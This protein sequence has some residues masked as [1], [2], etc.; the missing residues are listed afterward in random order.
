[1]SQTEFQTL[2]P[3]PSRLMT[4]SSIYSFK[5]KT[6]ESSVI[7]VFISISTTIIKFCWIYLKN[8]PHHAL[9][10]LSFLLPPR[11]II[12]LKT[13]PDIW[14]QWNLKFIP[15]SLTQLVPEEPWLYHGLFCPALTQL[16]FSDLLSVLWRCKADFSLTPSSFCSFSQNALSPDLHMDVW[17]SCGSYFSCHL[18]CILPDHAI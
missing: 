6:Q 13:S 18:L 3:T 17:L 10:P 7:S 16:Q 9:I 2:L 12:C 11:F 1:M 14:L 4:P 8:N 15:V 5:T